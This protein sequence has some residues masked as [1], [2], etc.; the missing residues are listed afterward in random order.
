MEIMLMGMGNVIAIWFCVIG[1]GVVWVM[2]D[3]YDY[4]YNHIPAVPSHEKN[5]PQQ[6]NH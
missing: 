3:K 1:L 4:D 5:K 2:N 6:Y